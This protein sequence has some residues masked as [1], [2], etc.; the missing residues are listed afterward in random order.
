MAESFDFF[1]SHFH[2]IDAAG[3]LVVNNDK[4]LF[5]YKNNKWDLPKGKIEEKENSEKAALRE[6]SEETGL[7]NIRLKKFLTKKSGLLSCSMRISDS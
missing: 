5:I 1:S 2:E 7:V 4:F 3:G 6:V